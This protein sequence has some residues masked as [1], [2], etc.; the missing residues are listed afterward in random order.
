M[1]ARMQENLNSFFGS[2]Q[3]LFADAFAVHELHV[4][5]RRQIVELRDAY[6]DLGVPSDDWQVSSGPRQPRKPALEPDMARLLRYYLS[7]ANRSM[8]GGNA[9]DTAATWRREHAD[10]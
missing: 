5:W 1:L 2:S 7:M 9:Q 8:A 3:D 10:Y 4:S 6:T